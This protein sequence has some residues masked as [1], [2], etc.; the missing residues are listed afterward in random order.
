MK[1]LILLF[2]PAMAFAQDHDS[3]YY[4]DQAVEVWQKAQ[5]PKQETQAKTEKEATAQVL[6]NELINWEWHENVNSNTEFK[7]WYKKGH[8]YGKAWRKLKSE[9]RQAW[10]DYLGPQVNITQ[11]ALEI[12]AQRE[13]AAKAAKSDADN[14]REEMNSH[15]SVKPE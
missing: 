7:L 12:N 4:E 13:A 8:T 15:E 2:L 5:Q 9:N 6:L 3:K 14:L 11:M 1:Y 10:F